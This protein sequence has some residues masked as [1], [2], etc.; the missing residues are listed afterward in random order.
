VG[1]CHTSGYSIAIESKAGRR[2][3]H[4]K[5]APMPVL[6]DE[7]RAPKIAADLPRR[8]FAPIAEGYYRPALVLSLFQYRQWHRFLLSRLDLPPGARVL[9]MATGTGALA[10][11]L[12]ARPGVQVVAGDITRQMLLQAQRRANGRSAGRLGLVECTAEAPPFAAGSFDAITFAYLLRYVAD[13]TEALRALAGLV[14]PGGTMASLDFAVPRGV[15]YPLW[16][17]YTDAVLPAGGRLFSR[18]WQD[19]G[20][21]LGRS[22]RE[23]Y[24]RWREGSLLEAWRDAGFRDVRSRRLSLGGAIVIWGRKAE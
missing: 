9:D 4:A 3:V 14:K 10:F 5:I 15:W 21:F 2:F 11:D 13:V 6:S 8:V 19:V 7:A 12:L 24:G 22:I 23:F 1:L 17:V 20:A 18:D 16:R